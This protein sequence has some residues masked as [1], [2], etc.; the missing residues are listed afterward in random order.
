[1]MK[2]EV[3][4]KV[5]TVVGEGT[6]VDIHS[7]NYIVKVGDHTINLG[8]EG[9]NSMKIGRDDLYF[10][11]V[12]PSAIVPSKRDEDAGYDVYACFD[13]DYLVIQPHETKLVPSGIATAFSPKYVAIIKER[14]SNGSKGIA[15]RCGVIDSGYRN[16]WFIPLTNTTT[17]TVVISKVPKEE[18]PLMLQ[19]G[20]IYP[21]TKGIAQFIMVEVP[22]M[23]TY[24][25]DFETLK[26]FESERGTGCLGSSGK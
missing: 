15:Q 21:Y 18:L 11:K 26:A 22:K 9:L 23:N 2:F 3:G 14:G 24:E 20:I 5:S 19:D 8:E 12:K 10:A 7:D 16:E 1:M 25:V 17:K 6:I 13:E 4:M